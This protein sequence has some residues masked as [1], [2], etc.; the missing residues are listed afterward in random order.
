MNIYDIAK[1]ANVSTA[2]VSR[3]VNGSDKVSER[4]R[5]KVLAVIDKVGFTPNVFAQGMGLNTMHTVGILVPSI[6]DLHM[7]MAVA[8]LEKGLGSYG[9]NC[10][11]GCSGFE[12]GQKQEHVEMLLSKHVDALVMVGS[13]YAGSG[14]NV[15]DT[16]YIRDAA[17]RVPVFVINGNVHG[18]NIYA[19]VNDDEKAVY[20]TVSAIVRRGRKKILF[21]TDSDSYSARKKQQGYEAA[22]SDAGIPILGELKMHVKNDVEYVRDLLLQYHR[23]KFDAAMATEDKIAIGV[24]KYAAVK[25]ISVPE[26]VSVVGYNNS[27]MAR[28][29]EPEL[30]SIDNHLDQ[31][32]QDT[33]ERM[34]K[35]LNR[36][37]K[38][39]DQVVGQKVTVPCSLVKRRT[40]DF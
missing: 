5:K 18:E 38:Q 14:E 30:T 15:H 24:L 39:A 17:G 29:C 13:T 4:T 32:C 27:E 1:M 19:A 10:I 33:V 25:G 21:L 20:D 35:V 9:Y 2:T 37:E 12:K 23:L 6:S 28:I 3:V 11:L 40:T 36:D 7:S 26:E 8:Y 22:L 34:I 31:L 16:D